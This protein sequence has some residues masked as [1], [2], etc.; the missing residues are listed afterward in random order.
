MAEIS[1]HA[2]LD[3]LLDPITRCFTPAVAEKITAIRADPDIQGRL[4]ELASKSNDGDLTE[5]ERREYEAYVEALDI[6]GVLQAKARAMLVGP[7]QD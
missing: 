2:I 3:R 5:T 7:S 1:E 6:V 4:D